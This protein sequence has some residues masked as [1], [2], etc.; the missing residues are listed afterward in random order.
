MRTAELGEPEAGELELQRRW[1]EGRWPAPWL[2]PEGGGA[3]LRV[4]FAGRWNRAAG[5]DFRGAILLDGGGRA[6]RGDV[7][8]HRRPSGWRGH[9]HHRD[10]AYARVLLHVVGDLGGANAG[11]PAALL[12]AAEPAALP[13]APPCARVV[14]RAG[15]AA[16]AARLRRLAAQR[17]R[18]KAAL[19]AQR[20]AWLAS[21]RAGSGG[22][23]DDELDDLLSAW[24]LARA[25][26]MPR[27]A[28]LTGDALQAA[29]LTVEQEIDSENSTDF[30]RRAAGGG[31]SARLRERL[32]AELGAGPAAQRWRHGRGALGRPAGAADA[33]AALLTRWERTGGA[34]QACLGLAA[35]EPRAAVERL[36]LSRRI[37]AARARQLLADAVYPA[38]LALGGLGGLGALGEP[39]AALTQRWLGLPETRY[40][41]TA[42][43]R[44]R[45][46]GPVD[47]SDPGGRLRLRHG[48]AQALL[49]LERGWCAQGA[50]AVCPLG[51]MSRRARPGAG[52][53]RRPSAL[54]PSLNVPAQR[55]AGK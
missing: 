8:L 26:G 34:A 38:A 31:R 27:N 1:A 13:P 33:L 39:A 18:R 22:E 37:G 42:A 10:P 14:E 3:P 36:R 29:W 32:I 15:G 30:H 47:R 19:L 2:T 21:A 20:R 48:E 40:L 24:A 16:V 4:H 51:R 53:A 23:P 28:E 43:L 17:L 9:G 7:E 52:A 46:V 35:L 12:P 49:E 50:C 45:L 6:R 5:P 54:I 11:P 44:E 55:G 25:L 41:R